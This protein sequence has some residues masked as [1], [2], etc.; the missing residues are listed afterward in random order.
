[1]NNRIFK[2]KGYFFNE[3]IYTDGVGASIVFVNPE[4]YSKKKTKTENINRSKAKNAA[5][6]KGKSK[7]EKQKNKQERSKIVEKKNVEYK[8]KQVAEKKA[9][10]DKYKKDRIIIKKKKEQEL[11]LLSEKEREINIINSQKEFPYLEDLTKDQVEQLKKSKLVYVDPGKIRLYTMIDDIQDKKCK[12]VLKYSHG[13]YMSARKICLDKINKLREQYKVMDREKELSNFNSKSTDYATFSLYV[14]EKNKQNQTLL[15]DYK[16]LKFRKYKWYSYM[17]KQ[18]EQSN[19]VSLIK[20]KYG[21]DCKLIMGDWCP[22]FQMRGRIATPMIGL[23]RELRKYFEIINLDEYNTSKLYHLTE[24]ETENMV[25]EVKV[26]KRDKDRKIQKDENNNIIT[27]I[28]SRKI[29]SL[30][31][32]KTSTS[33]M[34]IINR[35]VNSV[36]NMR[37]IVNSWLITGTRLEAY[38]RKKQEVE[39]KSLLK[40]PKRVSKAKILKPL[41]AKKQVQK[42]RNPQKK[43]SP[44]CKQSKS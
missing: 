22:S 4:E 1:M 42:K 20:K 23:K 13:Q 5:L 38:S 12:N 26:A 41:V 7:E 30:L 31:T 2:K 19:L 40:H 3:I 11:A 44:L 14:E 27:E 34:D 32:C 37:K 39:L 21:S 10:A 36:K 15:K 6:D 33:R 25:L 9:N 18:K 17:E 35:D 29:H 16:D 8:E 28:K 43:T 24:K